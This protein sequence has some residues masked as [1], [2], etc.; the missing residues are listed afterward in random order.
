MRTRKKFLLGAVAATLPLATVTAF[1]TGAFAAKAPP[2]P[3]SCQLSATVNVSPALTV[4]G[5][6]STK[7]ATGTATANAT[8]FNCHTSAGSV[9]NM[10]LPLTIVTPASKPGSDSAAIAAGDNKKSYYLGLCGNFASSATI[11]D[12]KKAVKNLAFEG[13]VLKGA[14]PS[15][16]TV[17][18]D[19]GFNID[20]GTV[21]GGTFPTAS[22][23]AS[24][25]AGL[26]NDANNSNLIG[27]CQGG[28]VD[29]IDID[30]SVS[31]ATL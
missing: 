12:L 10:S 30:S 6:L 16:G 5:Q 18:A 15:Q 13:G 2:N 31:T 4:A 14:K 9:P 8:L 24:I 19:V 29:H 26:T 11:K 28:P 25:A 22:H 23:G 7:G 20:N 1:G 3:V 21:K 27:G 17:G